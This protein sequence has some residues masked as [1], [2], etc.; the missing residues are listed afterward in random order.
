MIATFQTHSAEAE[1]SVG[2]GVPLIHLDDS[3][4]SPPS[5]RAKV[6]D[7]GEPCSNREHLNE[8]CLHVFARH[9]RLDPYLGEP[10][11]GSNG[12]FWDLND[13]P[14]FRAMYADC[15]AEAVAEFQMLGSDPNDGVIIG[16]MLDSFWNAKAKAL[17]AIQP[18]YIDG[19]QW[20]SQKDLLKLSGG[21]H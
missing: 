13:S 1:L 17:S 18:I 11:D 15:V 9:A 7:I 21:R 3:E 2:G 20:D 5:Q 8:L 16:D 4:T 12:I 6:Y 14:G 19:V 10:H